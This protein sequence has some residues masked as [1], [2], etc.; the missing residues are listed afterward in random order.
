MFQLPIQYNL[1][2]E[3]DSTLIQYLELEYVFER[4]SKYFSFF[5][6]LKK[7]LNFLKINKLPFRYNMG[8]TTFIF[9]KNEK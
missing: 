6:Y 8:Q 4:A 5:K 3:V 9:K 7:V 2:N 1:P